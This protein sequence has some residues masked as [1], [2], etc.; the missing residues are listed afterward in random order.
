MLVN[1]TLS[2]TGDDLVTID[3]ESWRRDLDGTLT[4][5][6]LCSKAVL[7]G[8]IERGGGRDR[9]H[10]VRERARLLRQ[11]AVQRREG[12]ADQPHAQHGRALRQ[13]RD[14]R[15]RDRAR[16]DPL[17]ALAGARGQGA[18]SSSGSSAGTRWAASA[19]P[20]TSR[21]R[22]A[23]LASDDASWISGEVLRVDGGLLAGNAQMARELARESRDDESSVLDLCFRGGRVIDGAGNPWYRADVGIAAAASPPSAASTSPRGA[24]STRD[25][26][27]AL[28]GLHRH[29]HAL[30][31]AAARESRP[32]G[33][34]HQGVTLDVLGQDG[35]SYAPVN[36]ATLE[37]LRGQLAGWNDDPPGSTGAGA[38]S[39]STSTGFDARRDRGQRRLPRSARHDPHAARWA[40][41]TAPPT[42]DELA[43]M[44]RLLRQGA[45]AGRRRPLDRAHLHA[46]DVRRRRRD[47][48]A[49]R[50]RAEHGGLLLPAPPQLRAARARGLRRLHRDRAP[51]RRAAAP[52][53]R[54]PRLR[55]QQ[56]R[57]PASCSR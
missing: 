1:N 28:P 8:M 6:F 37:Q 31:P 36:D 52:R 19:S 15:R 4:S 23:F 49:L 46:G 33:K 38:P 55:D 32:R 22:R 5:A 41:T 54:A 56:G 17:A 35:L 45:R 26:L 34:V 9:E 40:P 2:A 57:A 16:H 24:R 44:K 20:R 21:T 39:A 18:R 25:G 43:H 10:R 7:P 50:G 11:R 51:L 27:F 29:A 42:P 47:R 13:A 53:A 48:R 14:P 30:R 12:R 3:E